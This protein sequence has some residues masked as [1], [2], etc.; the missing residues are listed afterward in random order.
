[1]RI[2]LC[3][4][5]RFEQDFHR[6]NEDLSLAGHVVYALAAWPSRHAG[7]KD[8]YDEQ[9]KIALDLVHL[10]KIDNSDA[11]VVI[12][13]GGYVGPSTAREVEWARMKNKTVYYVE[14][15]EGAGWPADSLLPGGEAHRR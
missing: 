4:S 13:V 7:V 3:G 14:P 9:Q 8:W 11:V 12:N 10:A 2:T 5:A 6:W 15:V 1:M